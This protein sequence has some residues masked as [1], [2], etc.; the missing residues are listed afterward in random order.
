MGWL[1]GLL[2]G[3]VQPE[4]QKNSGNSDVLNKIMDKATEGFRNNAAGKA[5]TEASVT[6]NMNLSQNYN[7]SPQSAPLKGQPMNFYGGETVQ[8]IKSSSQHK[9]SITGGSDGLKSNGDKSFYKNV[10]IPRKKV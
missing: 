9:V 8:Q 1:L 5:S 7:K 6:S 4:G 10:V 3:G 2:G